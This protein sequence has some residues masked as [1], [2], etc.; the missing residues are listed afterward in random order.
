MVVHP[1]KQAY[2]TESAIW[3]DLATALGRDRA[4]RLEVRY[5]K[6]L[7]DVLV[8]LGAGR[9]AWLELKLGRRL[10]NGGHSVWCAPTLTLEQAIWLG[11]WRASGGYVG[12]LIAAKDELALV[13]FGFRE[14]RTAGVV[15]AW[16]GQLPVDG[17]EL[18]RAMTCGG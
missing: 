17:E 12:V 15:P 1:A 5:P 14:L 3:R 2:R 4:Q 9:A 18:L 6:G 7:P 16:T 11:A 10:P 8:N 13:T